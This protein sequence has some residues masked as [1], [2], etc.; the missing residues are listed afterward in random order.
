MSKTSLALSPKTIEV[1]QYSKNADSVTFYFD[2]YVNNNLDLSTFTSKIIL[3]AKNILISGLNK[4]LVQE[5]SA[6][7]VKV[8][9]NFDS[10]VTAKSGEYNFQIAFVDQRDIVQ[11]YSSVG[12]LKINKSLDVPTIENVA[13]IENLSLLKQWQEYME[14]IVAKPFYY[15]PQIEN[16]TIYWMPNS[17]LLPEID[18]IKL[19]FEESLDAIKSDDIKKLF[20]ID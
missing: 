11:L 13:F 12:K 8:T 2:R 6:T 9:W 18:S 3:D 14:D 19:D 5:Y 16:D 7:K 17:E 20:S 10:I 15:T 1:Q 4:T